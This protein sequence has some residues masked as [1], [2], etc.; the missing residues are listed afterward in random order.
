[1]LLPFVDNLMQAT[2]GIPNWHRHR[3]REAFFAEGL[4]GCCSRQI[5]RQWAPRTMK[6]TAF[7][8]PTLLVL[9]SSAFV[10]F[11]AWEPAVTELR[12]IGDCFPSRDS[13]CSGAFLYLQSTSTQQLQYH[14]DR[15]AAVTPSA[16][17]SWRSTSVDRHL[18]CWEER[19]GQHPGVAHRALPP[20]PAVPSRNRR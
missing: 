13:I 1:M 5:N 6:M 3:D 4:M 11:W 9:S 2:D 14:Q 8:L 16:C 20:H 15:Q 19:Q 17:L 18:P 10:Y 12:K 7:S